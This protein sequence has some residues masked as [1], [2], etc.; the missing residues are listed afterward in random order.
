[1]GLCK[2][3]ALVERLEKWGED[4][5]PEVRAA[6]AVLW[7]DYPGPE[8]RRALTRLASDKEAAVRRAV[9]AAVGYLQSAELLPLLEGFLRDAD[10]RVRSAA[11]MSLVSFDP[12]DA[13]AVLR[14]FKGDPDYRA[15]FVNALALAEPKAYLDELARI[16]RTN[17]EPKLHFV[18]QMPVYTSWQILKAE[19]E[20]RPG[21]ELAGGEFDAYLDAL[22]VPPNI[23]SG[24]YTEVY[25]FY[26]EKGLKA[27]AGRFREEVKRRVSTYD[28]DYFFKRVDE[29][30]VR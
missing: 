2:D 30:V 23:G 1:M 29:E 16:V 17:D 10:E 9:A 11:A 21:A 6:A 13:E 19:M 3:A 14:R 24:P 8:A 18:A 20:S 4:P 28:I 5:A 15:G 26:L 27:R 22:E 12:K 7:S 25:R